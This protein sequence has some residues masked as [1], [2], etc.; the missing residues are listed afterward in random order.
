MSATA[1]DPSKDPNFRRGVLFAAFMIRQAI[2]ASTEDGR[3][4]LEHIE[5]SPCCQEA[6]TAFAIGA[7]DGLVKEFGR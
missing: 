1:S 6:V 3:S 2:A 4:A 7:Y 5:P